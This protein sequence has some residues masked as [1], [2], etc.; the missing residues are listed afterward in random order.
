MYNEKDT[1]KMIIDLANNL[2]YNGLIL[3]ER[4]LH[5][6]FSFLLQDKMGN[7]QLTETTPNI[8]L[9]PEWPTY[10]SQADLSYGRYKKIYDGT[11]QPDVSGTAGFIDFTIGSYQAPDIG[12]EFSLKYGWSNEEVTYDFVKLL[13][14]TNPFKAVISLNI[15]FRQN[16]LVEGRNLKNLENRIYSTIAEAK[17]RL[18]KRVCDKTRKIYFII[19]EIDR[20]NK[21]K[22]WFYTELHKNFREGLPEVS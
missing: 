16:R 7:I 21:R 2:K 4:Y 12:I 15:I 11:Y 1:V 20:Q 5:H 19:S 10:K 17:K 22:H 9:H 14:N 3:N 18:K 8:L 13:D 6:L